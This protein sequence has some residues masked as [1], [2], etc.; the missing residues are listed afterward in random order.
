MSLLPQ[1]LIDHI[2]EMSDLD[3]D[4]R[5]ALKIRPKKLNVDTRKLSYLFFVRSLNW[6]RYVRVSRIELF[7]VPLGSITG[8]SWDTGIPRS[9]MTISISV[10][11]IDGEALLEFEKVENIKPPEEDLER[12]PESII[13]SS[14]HCKVQTGEIIPRFVGEESDVD[15]DD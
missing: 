8:P 2:L 12:W 9:T 7:T 1:H 3:I 5:L 11:Y 13:R 15:E 4:K 6:T 14:V 10:W